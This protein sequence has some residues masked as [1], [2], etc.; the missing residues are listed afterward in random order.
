VCGRGEKPAFLW[1]YHAERHSRGNCTAT[2][3]SGAGLDAQASGMTPLCFAIRALGLRPAA[4][5]PRPLS[6]PYFAALA[7]A[8]AAIPSC[9]P[10]PPLAPIAPTILP[11]TVI[12]RPPSDA[13]GLSGKV[14]NAVFPAAY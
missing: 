8:A 11:L 14:V 7:P 4:I 13:T 9:W 3:P 2:G 10:V 12:G 1:A 6:A 5:S